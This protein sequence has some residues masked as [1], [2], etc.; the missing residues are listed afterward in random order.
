MKWLIFQI[1]LKRKDNA[2]IE[3]YILPVF[4]QKCYF[5]PWNLGILKKTRPYFSF[6]V[7]LIILIQVGSSDQQV[8]YGYV[9]SPIVYIY[10]YTN[11]PHDRLEWNVTLYSALRLVVFL[12]CIKLFLAQFC[13]AFKIV[14]N[15]FISNIWKSIEWLWL[16]TLPY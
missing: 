7:K 3:N 13:F 4:H 12:Y 6:L 8:C 9:Y 15:F 10:P 5:C 16:R 11:L 2:K 14:P 1:Y